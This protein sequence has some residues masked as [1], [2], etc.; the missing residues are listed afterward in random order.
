MAKKLLLK[1]VLHNWGMIC[2]ANGDWR[3]V[4]WKVFC[5]GTYE[6][7]EE[8]GIKQSMEDRVD[9]ITPHRVKETKWTEHR[10][11]KGKMNRDGFQCLMEAM[12][13]DPWRDP[14]IDSDGCDGVA[15][16]IEQ[17]AD[18]RVVR[19][20]GE[21][22]YIYGQ[23]NLERIVSLLPKTAQSYGASAY[24]SVR[25]PHVGTNT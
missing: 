20:S 22:D 14:A 18:G 4:T 8:V 6:I 12:E 21:L 19:S 15:W 17:Y 11:T 1:A 2:L 3:S 23:A 10:I 7:D 24:V 16:M 5:D 25:H 13:Q 9:L